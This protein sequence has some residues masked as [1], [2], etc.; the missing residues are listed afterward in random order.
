MLSPAKQQL[1]QSMAEDLRH[2][3]AI[4]TESGAMRVLLATRRY[5]CGDI[6]TLIDGARTYAAELIQADV[7]RLIA[8]PGR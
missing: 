6:V 7:A 3:D 5:D 2:A 8:E 4:A 1:M